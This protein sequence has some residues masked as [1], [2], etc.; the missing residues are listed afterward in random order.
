MKRYYKFLV[1]WLINVALLYLVAMFMPANF[2]LGNDIFTAIQAALFTGFVWN[3]VLWNA[4]STFKD[5]EIDL[6]S[7]MAMMIVYLGV[8]FVTIW[9]LARFAFMSGFGVSSYIY[10]FMLALVGNLLQYMAWRAMDKKK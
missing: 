3:W 8:N 1:F 5:L 2:K 10:V 7:P 4:E 9:L 6:Q